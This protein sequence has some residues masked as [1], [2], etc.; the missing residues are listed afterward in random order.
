MKLSLKQRLVDY[1]II[2]GFVW[3]MYLIWLIPFQIFAI[4]LSW[5]QFWDWV[6]Y[7]TLLEMIFTYPIAKMAIKFGPRITKWVKKNVG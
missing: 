5:T 1:L 7:G 4:H 6:I 2:T 3:G